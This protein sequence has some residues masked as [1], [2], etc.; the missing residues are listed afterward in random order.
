LFEGRRVLVDASFAAESRRKLF[1]DAAGR[2]GVPAAMI[3]C[4]TASAVIE[5]RLRDRRNDAS[6]AD[7][8]IYQQ[9]AA[10]W[11]LPGPETQARAWMID[12]DRGPE[13]VREEALGVLRACDLVEGENE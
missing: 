3:V 11:E 10:R 4:Q 7:W 2:W 13:A 1:L 8:A 5:Q 12:T 6:D 9:A